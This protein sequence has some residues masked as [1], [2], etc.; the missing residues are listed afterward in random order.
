M[1][2][3]KREWK[4]R[5]NGRRKEDMEEGKRLWKKG[6]IKQIRC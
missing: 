4:E 1:E 2:E 5:G 6:V 3:V